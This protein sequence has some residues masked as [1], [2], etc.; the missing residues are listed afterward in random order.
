[1]NINLRNIGGNA[2]S[3]LTSDVTN[4]ATSF[5]IYALI[6]RHLG[7]FEFGQLAL[8]FSLFYVFQVTAV[9]GLK[10][11]II[12]QVAKDRSQ[13]KQYFL[14][15]CFIVTATSLLSIG[16]LFGFVR[17]MHY[18][19]KT[20]AIILAL[21]LALLPYALSAVC[22]GVFQAWERMRYI[23]SINVP[24]NLAKMAAAYLLLA[25]G[26]GLIPV[27]FVLFT[28]FFGVAVV[29]MWLVL[30]RFPSPSGRLSLRFCWSTIRSS[31]T[32]LAIDKIIAIDSSL[33]IILL[34]KLATETQVGLYTAAA[35]LLVPLALVYQ[36]ISQSIYPVMCRHVH[37]GLQDLKRISERA[38]EALLMLALPAVAGIYFLGPWALSLLYK[39]QTFLEAVPAL[40]IMVWILIFQVFSYV[41]GQVLMATH[42][43]KI[44][45]RIVI[46]DVL[47]TLGAGWPLISHFGLLGAA[48]TFFV[49]RLIA[50]VQHFIPVSR[51]L[52]GISLAKVSWRPVVATSCMA[53]YLAFVSNEPGI[54]R[55]LVATVIYAAALLALVLFACGGIRQ[56]KLQCLNAWQGSSSGGGEETAHD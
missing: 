5:I 13:T 21:S 6:A 49:T 14:N 50:A 15:G 35:Q 2:L 29:E 23:A 26:R 28:A 39:K 1:M 37:A 27:V 10:L 24:A 46:V 54:L 48:F 52:S 7:A 40:R 31:L 20:S 56:L 47:V 55:A 53:G 17:L 4:R 32:F 11:L 3:V 8:S 44:T 45:L 41:L 30:R 22:E 18:E 9:A 25:D 34:S 16:L 42:R 36:S 43:E 33:N 51:L 38:M 12:R 19:A